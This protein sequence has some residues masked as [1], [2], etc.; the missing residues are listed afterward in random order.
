MCGMSGIET[1]MAILKLLKHTYYVEDAMLP[2][3]IGLSGHV[4]KNYEKQAQ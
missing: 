2:I 4:G 3:V 1:T